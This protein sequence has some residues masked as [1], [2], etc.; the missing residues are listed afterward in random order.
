MHEMNE[1][2]A[3]KASETLEDFLIDVGNNLSPTGTIGEY[4]GLGGRYFSTGA[5][6]CC[7]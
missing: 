5:G 2:D 3:I 6:C 7:C 4:D 1:M